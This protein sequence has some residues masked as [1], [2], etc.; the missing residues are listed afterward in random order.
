MQVYLKHS[1]ATVPSTTVAGL[2]SKLSLLDQGW[3]DECMETVC[4]WEGDHC[5]NISPDLA[6][7]ELLTMPDRGRQWDR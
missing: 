3:G 4:R 6:H 1:Q 2:P 7:R 5:G